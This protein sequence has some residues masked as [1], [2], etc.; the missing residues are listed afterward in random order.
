MRKSK[1]RLGEILLKEGLITQTQLDEALRSQ[2]SNGRAIGDI[3]VDKGFVSEKDVANSLAKQLDIPFVSLQDSSLTPSGDEELEKLVPAKFARQQMILPLA[4]HLKSLTV[5]FANPL[6][7]LTIDNLKQITGCEINP[8]IATRSDIREAINR[9]YGEKNLLKEMVEESYVPEEGMVSVVEEM[10][11]SLEDIV[12]KA[13]EAPVI[14]LVDLILIQAVK[15]RASDIH[16]EPFRDQ[17]IVRF[18]IDGVLHKIAPPSQHLLPA[19]ISRIKILSKMDIAEKRLP[20]DGGF[21]IKI[22]DRPIDL[23][24]SIIPT[25]FGE[26]AVL[27]IL[28]KGAFS[29]ELEK[30]GFSEEE[31]AKFKNCITKPYGLI[32]VTGPTGCGKSTTLYSVLSFIKTPKKNIITIEDPVEYHVSGVNQVQVKPK[33][34]LT[35]AEGLRCFLRQ[36]PDIIM[37]GEVRDLE[38][39]EICIRAGLTGHLVFSTL[40]TNDAP[41]AITRLVDIGI[42]P[43]LVASGLLLI[44]AQRLVRKLCPKCKVPLELTADLMK[45]YNITKRGIYKAKGCEF[46]RQTGYAGRTAIFEILEI[47]DEIRDLIAEHASMSRLRE[48]TK[49]VGMK[50][51]L[52]DGMQRVADG[53]TSVEEVMSVT[54]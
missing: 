40:H 39:A 19:L 44:M 28:D 52:E 48:A 43:Y 54:F 41:S 34:G 30:L 15:E 49:R 29:F 23:R 1:L 17:I 27:R 18:R 3:V 32:F 46:C 31:L 7:L 8:V 9:F 37:V 4:K 38:T 47:N 5:V 42:E 51:L 33:I 26:K 21:M 2:R 14:K 53:I 22:E 24:V 35:F 20:Q 50:T 12:A 16:I 36:D 25:I 13:E 6:D 10:K 11:E 45:K